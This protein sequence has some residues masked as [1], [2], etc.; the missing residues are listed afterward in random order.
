MLDVTKHAKSAKTEQEPLPADDLI[1]QQIKPAFYADIVI[2]ILLLALLFCFAILFYLQKNAHYLIWGIVGCFLLVGL[3]LVICLSRRLI[4]ILVRTRFENRKLFQINKQLEKNNKNLQAEISER[5]R[6]EHSL[7]ALATYD[8]LTGLPNRNL[9]HARLSHAGNR[10]LRLG[11][12]VALLFLDLDHFKKVNDSLGHE[13]G[14]QLL[15]QVSGRLKHALRKVD[16]VARIGGDE[17]TIILEELNNPEEAAKLAITLCQLIAN[18]FVIDSHN[19]FITASIGISLYPID[20]EEL[21][22]L[23][24][25]ADTAMYRA[26]ENGRNNYEFYTLE[27]ENSVHTKRHMEI[28]L[29]KAIERNE[30]VLY[31][32]PQVDIK[33]QAIISAEVLLRWQHPKLGNIEPADF[34][35]TAD[36]IG[37]MVTL[38]DWIIRTSCAQN[39]VWQQNGFNAVPLSINLS[40]HQ[41]MDKNFIEKITAILRETKISGHFLEFEIAEN[42]LMQNID[43][44]LETFQVLKSL[45]I[46]FSIDDFGIGYSSLSYLKLL[47]ITSLK[48]AR[49]FM[50]K[51]P[52]N[53][54]DIPVIQ[55]IIALAHSLNLKVIAEGVETLEQVNLLRQLGCDAAQGYYFSKPLPPESFSALLAHTPC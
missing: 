6:V 7:E 36:E 54:D 50:V 32:Q 46:R 12:L 40:A 20:S 49:S 34:I 43:Y 35:P 27:M 25:Y 13:I 2:A 37:A 26:K 44:A 19:I 39:Q 3:F 22:T 9:F 16:T 45:G 33:T 8:V 29:H 48:I 28:N 21:Q 24:K 15:I 14:D 42:V 52:Q 38:S 55:A 23:I 47:P 41:F 17:F 4:S 11:K 31:Y 5:Q 1:Y 53:K 51:V 18:P 10:S 30:F